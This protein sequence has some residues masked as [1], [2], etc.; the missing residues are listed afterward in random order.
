MSVNRR[1]ATWNI[2]E[3]PINQFCGHICGIDE[4]QEA[5]G[6]TKAETKAEATKTEKK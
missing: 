4:T 5:R 2:V 1:I 3:S 6:G